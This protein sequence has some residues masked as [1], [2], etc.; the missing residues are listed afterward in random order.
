VQTGT[1]ALENVTVQFV[2]VPIPGTTIP[3]EPLPVRT[4]D[5]PQELAAVDPPDTMP[6][7]PLIS[8]GESQLGNPF[9]WKPVTNPVVCINHI[10]SWPGSE[11]RGRAGAA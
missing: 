11:P 10:P 4:G 7:L 5:V 2:T 9:D 6:I 3:A 1:K 8:D